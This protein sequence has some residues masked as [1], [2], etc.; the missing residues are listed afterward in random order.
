MLSCYCLSFSS[1]LSL[2]F[3]PVQF[4]SSLSL[5]LS[6]SIPSSLTFFS[7]SL[8]TLRSRLAD[9]FANCQPEPRS[10]S[11]CLKESYADCLLAYSGLIGTVMTPN[12]L[13]TPTISVSPWCDCSSSGNGKADCDKFTEFFTDNRCLRNAIQAFG[14]GTDVGV[15][16]PQPPIQPTPQNPNT[17]PR[18]RPGDKSTN[19]VDDPSLPNRLLEGDVFRFCGNLQAQKLKSNATLDTSLCVLD[20]HSTS[21]IVQNAAGV[22]APLPGPGLLFLPLLLVPF[23]SSLL[24]LPTLPTSSLLTA[25]LG[26]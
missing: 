3:Y 13:R 10:V 26:L 20:D 24:Q 22:A 16:Q 14:N 21:S 8:P 15:W 2:S 25:L 7:L 18:G 5:I 1:S 11:G 19:A 12:Y 9:F 23:T 4:S 17:P 6:L